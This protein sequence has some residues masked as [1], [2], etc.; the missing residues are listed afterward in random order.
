MNRADRRRYAKEVSRGTIGLI[1]Q[2]K[3]SLVPKELVDSKGRHY[4]DL[5]KYL[6]VREDEIAQEL[7]EKI[8]VK[9]SEISSEMLYHAEDYMAAANLI[10]MLHTVQ[11]TFGKLK[12]VEKGLSKILDNYNK[13]AEYVDSIGVKAAYRELNE[14]YGISIEFDENFEIDAIFDD[15]SVYEKYRIIMAG[16]ADSE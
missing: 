2:P 4:T 5:N 8:S 11:R 14:K 13:T 12:T 7:A 6:S 10:I 16:K 15:K 1:E 3:S 9:C